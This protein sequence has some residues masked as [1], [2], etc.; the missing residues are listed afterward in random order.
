MSIDALAL[1]IS[2]L[3]CKKFAV[4]TIHSYVSAIGYVH[5]LRGIGD[6]TKSFLIQKLLTATSRNRVSDTRLPIS[7]PLLHLL[8]SSLCSTNSS[9]AQRKRYAAMF[10]T[11][12]YGFFR[13][14]ELAVKN[15]DSGGDVLQY[16]DLCFISSNGSISMAKLTIRKFKHNTAN[17]A[18]EILIARE[19]SVS[20][21]P[22]QTLLDCCG[23]RGAA[24]GPLF[25]ESDL[26]PVTI[27]SFNTELKRC[28]VFCGLD[29][30][31]YKGHSFRI[32]AATHASEQ[33]FSDSQIRKLGRWQSDAFK[34]YLRSGA[35]SANAQ[36][37]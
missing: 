22:V 2:Y 30:S 27:S 9:A 13:I 34:T 32:G 17:K 28:L 15:V 16:D 31:R 29:T 11:P 24:S 35:L 21:C 25:C 26:P 7:C 5:R 1:F 6:P 18:F 19:N 4:A 10:T 23:M 12:F 37:D 14:G 3:S 20:V 8:V 33:G 36:N